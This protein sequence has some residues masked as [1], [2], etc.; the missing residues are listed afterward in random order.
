MVS[1][2][3]VAMKLLLG[4]VGFKNRIHSMNYNRCLRVVYR[5]NDWPGTD[6]ALRN[7]NLLSCR[8]R[9][10]LY[11]LKYA[12]KQSGKPGNLKEH[13]TRLLRSNRKLLLRECKCSNT[14]FE[15]SFLV[16]STKFWNRI[17]EEIKHI[18]NT[19]LFTTRVKQELLQGNIN[20][21]E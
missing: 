15:K 19:K 2:N 10:C 20:F 13:S 8:S 12:H 14:K 3:L 18:R 9:R 17:P 11:L 4:T 21:P 6:N 16:T 1:H 7:N 5:K